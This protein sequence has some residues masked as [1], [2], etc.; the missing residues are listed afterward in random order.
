[1]TM[2]A[3]VKAKA[4]K[5]TVVTLRDRIA[6]LYS[7]LESI[8]DKHAEL[9]DTEVRERLAE[10]L[11]H[12]FVW[13][14][15]FESEP[16]EY[17]MF[18]RTG[19]AAVSR[20]VGTFVGAAL[21]AAEL[22]AVKVGVQRHRALQDETIKTKSEQ[23]YDCFLGYSPK[24]IPARRQSHRS[25]DRRA[26]STSGEKK[27]KIS[28]TVATRRFL[29]AGRKAQT[30]AVR[31]GKPA[32]TRSGDWRCRFEVSGVGVDESGVGWGVDSLQALQQGL[33]G[34]RAALDRTEQSLSWLGVKP[35]N[36]TVPRS[37]PWQFGVEFASKLEALIETETT[38]LGRSAR[39]RYAARQRWKPS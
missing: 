29:V 35:A 2:K 21:K 33:E 38:A 18:S 28:L 23:T 6:E 19:N 14:H 30:I 5:G 25:A 34:L 3:K 7:S 13:G 8:G 22:E 9:Y 10:A 16:R 31:L 20:A 15:P 11:S 37:I 17:G 4:V 26:L 12:A 39:A 24:P 32:K 1:M 36:V 27:S